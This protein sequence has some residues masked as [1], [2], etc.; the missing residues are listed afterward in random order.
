[1][2]RSFIMGVAIKVVVFLFVFVSGF[3]SNAQSI[4]AMRAFFFAEDEEVM[5]FTVCA[6]N[7]EY[8]STSTKDYF[9]GDSLIYREH[10]YDI[11]T[12]ERLVLTYFNHSL[13]IYSL[14]VD[15]ELRVSGKLRFN[16][17]KAE[18]FSISGTFYDVSESN[19]GDY[20]D[21][22]GDYS[23][24]YGDFNDDAFSDDSDYSA[25]YYN[26]KG[27]NYT[28]FYDDTLSNHSV[29]TTEYYNNLEN[30]VSNSK[31]NYLAKLHFEPY[32][33]WVIIDSNGFP[34]VGFLNNKLQRE[35]HWFSYIDDTT[36]KETSYIYRDGKQV[37]FKQIN[38]LGLKKPVE[39]INLQRYSIESMT[40][41]FCSGLTTILTLTKLSDTTSFN[42]NTFYFGDQLRQTRA[43]TCGS[44]SE[45]EP[46]YS[47]WKGI[48]NDYL[49]F[50]QSI[51][52]VIYL[53]NEIVVLRL[54]K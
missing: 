7:Q 44:R 14:F 22:Y 26:D 52:K 5:E 28:A 4:Y 2:P 13:T 9:A 11:N 24:D 42:G 12:S 15:D 33:K 49:Q 30:T 32:G 46:H 36:L 41:D 35:G 39:M 48:G 17:E 6:D 47:K 18:N 21:E 25:E 43:V 51:W 19:G 16:L 37:D 45:P 54:K 31:C 20:D 1:M 27:E 23:D 38:L 50:G 53:S 8:V 10:I 3:K 29:D 40:P 34:N